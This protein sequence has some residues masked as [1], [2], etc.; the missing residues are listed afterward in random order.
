MALQGVGFSKRKPGTSRPPE[1]ASVGETSGSTLKKPGT[2]EKP[3]EPEVCNM[4]LIRQT[5]F[6]FHC[7]ERNGLILQ[8]RS[9]EPADSEGAVSEEE[10]L[11]EPEMYSLKTWTLRTGK[12]TTNEKDAPPYH[13]NLYVF[14][15]HPGGQKGKRN[16]FN[17]H[18]QISVLTKL[19]CFDPKKLLEPRNPR[20][21]QITLA[22]FARRSEREV[23]IFALISRFRARRVKPKQLL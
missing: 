3:S 23:G 14:K 10:V 21:H 16:Q 5:G 12:A 13:L 11:E 18:F 19:Q 15:E 4:L 7:F 8:E 1:E 22:I 20:S 6:L 17:F 2:E 9:E